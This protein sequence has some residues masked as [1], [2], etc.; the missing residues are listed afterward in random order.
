MVVAGSQRELS[1]AERD[2]L[3]ALLQ[4]RFEANMQRHPDVLRSEVC[5]ALEG[6]EEILWSLSEMERTGGEPDVVGVEHYTNSLLFGDCSPESPKGRRSLCYD[7]EALDSRKENKPAG[8]ALGMAEAMGIELMDEDQYQALQETG[9][10]DLKTSSWLRAPDEVRERGGAIFGDKRYGRGFIY[11]N[12]AESYYASRGFRGVLRA[13]EISQYVPVACLRDCI[14]KE[15]GDAEIILAGSISVQRA[16]SANRDRN[17][18][19]V[20]NCFQSIN[21]GEELSSLLEDNVA[22]GLLA[23]LGVGLGFRREDGTVGRGCDLSHLRYG[24]IILATQADEFGRQIRADLIRFFYEY[25]RALISEGH[26]WALATPLAPG[27]SQE[28]CDRE[29]LN[30]ETRNL[31]QLKNAE[32]WQEIVQFLESG[33]I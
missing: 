6:Q 17:T 15:I 9:D 21:F 32:T 16:A 28:D 5:Q 1:Q 20:L 25:M 2:A 19:A 33:S 12:G 14:P 8:S 13:G 3:T 10:F 22:R 27:F 7:Q 24:K 31:V 18:Q 11:H 26:V 4:Q 30:R 23:T 29:V